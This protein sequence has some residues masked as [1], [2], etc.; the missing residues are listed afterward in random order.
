MSVPFSEFFKFIRSKKIFHINQKLLL[1]SDHK[2]KINYYHNMYKRS[3]QDVK[4]YKSRIIRTEDILRSEIIAL[5]KKDISPFL[6]LILFL[7]IKR[8]K[9][10]ET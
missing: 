3:I 6:K 9:C 7:L 8:I 10:E 4:D 5:Q 2:E 1:I